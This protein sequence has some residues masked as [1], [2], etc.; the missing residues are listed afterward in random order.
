[1][2]NLARIYSPPKSAM[3]SGRGR[4]GGWVLEHEPAEQKRLDPMT[5]WFG[6]GDT[7]EQVR[8]HFEQKEQAVAYARAHGIAFEVEEAQPDRAAIRPRSYADNFRWNR[9]ENWTH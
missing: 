3:Q 9:T 5:G 1:M 2:R 6:S 7:Q 8:L 4:Q